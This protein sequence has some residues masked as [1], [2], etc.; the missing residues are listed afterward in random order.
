[1]YKGPTLTLEAG[2]GYSS[3]Y[4]N[5]GSDWRTIEVED[6]GDYSVKVENE[7]GCV[8]NATISVKLLKPKMV[9]PNVF[10]PNGKGPNEIFYP[11]FKGVVTDFEMYIYTRWG[12]QV[13]QL[14]KP[15]VAN[16][17]LKDEGWNGEYKGKE[18]AIG[19]YVWII[20]YGGK[21]Q[22]HGTVTLFR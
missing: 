18:S 3:Y 11:V 19:V 4:W 16:N 5:T 10:T 17:E 15:M 14:K 2:S 9:V 21:E 12:E 1:M 6:P 22:E 7:H 13:F 20:F 8:A